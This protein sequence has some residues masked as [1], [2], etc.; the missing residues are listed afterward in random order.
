MKNDNS[1]LEEFMRSNH[2]MAETRLYRCSLPEF[3]TP[4]D[5]PGIIEISANE[6]PSEAVIDVY[7]QGHITLAV[8]IAAGLAFA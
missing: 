4:T 7:E 6:D 5:E 3:T 8:H 1:K 2:L